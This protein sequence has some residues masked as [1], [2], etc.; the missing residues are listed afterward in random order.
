MAD[1]PLYITAWTALILGTLMVYLTFGVIFQRRDKKIVLGDDGDREIL[2]KIRGHAN[3][4]EQVPIA[5][6]LL[7]FVE[8][9][10]GS[11]IA[12]IIAA[13]L[14]VGRLLHACYFSYQGVNWRLRFT[15]ML[16]TM[17]AQALALLTLLYALLF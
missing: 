16:L 6:I 17:I 10:E 8:F 2:K 3:A 4:A 7:G 12:S 5:L 1:F 9:L 15:G 14:I 13:I 11:F